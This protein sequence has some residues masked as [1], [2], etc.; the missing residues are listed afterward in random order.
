LLIPIERDEILGCKK[1]AIGMERLNTNAFQLP[2][3]A[4]PGYP[5]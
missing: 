1:E 3:K 5:K 2:A 4:L